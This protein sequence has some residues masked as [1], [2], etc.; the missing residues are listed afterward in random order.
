MGLLA[1]PLILAGAAQL[2]LVELIDDGAPWIV[3]V[4]T[5]L[6][7]N[8]RFVMYSGALARPFADFPALRRYALTHLITD[9]AATTSLLEYEERDDP[10][11]RAAYFAGT[12][13]TLLVS[14]T[15]GTAVGLVFGSGVPDSW[16]VEFAVP[17]MFLALLIPAVRDRPSLITA[18]VGGRGDAGGQGRPVR[19]R[20]ADR[21]PRGHRGRGALQAAAGSR[22]DRRGVGR[23][24][25][26]NRRG[27]T[28]SPFAQVLLVTVGTYA[29]RA[30]LIV[31]LGRV[32]TPPRVQ[33]ALELVAPAALAGLVAQTLVLDGDGFRS[34]GAWYGAAVVAA[35]VGI[36]TRSTG[37]TLAAGMAALWTFAALG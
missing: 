13:V 20:P 10:D 25:E 15:T 12:G 22:P 30:S 2:A 19:Q 7:I 16:Q 34:F 31:V 17:L 35:L 14:W 8:A 6:F 28:M 32:T 9:Q 3:A 26:T 24:R 29:L 36:G 27:R 21:R 4:G 11:E 18:T 33:D 23:V 37:W 5:A 1:S